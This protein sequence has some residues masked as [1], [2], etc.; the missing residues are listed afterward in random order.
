MRV[1][2]RVV[3]PI[4]YLAVLA[5]IALALAWMAFRPSGQANADDALS[6]TG[7][8]LSSQV[9]VERGSISNVLQLNGRIE[10]D[11]PVQV[12]AS[13]TGTVNHI[14]AEPGQQVLRGAELFQIRTEDAPEPAADTGEPGEEA[15]VPAS[16]DAQRYRYHTVT[17]PEAGTVGEFQISAG[18]EVER[19]GVVTTLAKDS[20]R[21][22]AQIEPGQLYRLPEVPGTATITIIG[23]PEP[24]D[25]DRLR[26][27]QAGAPAGE[28]EEPAENSGGGPGLTCRVPDDVRVFH[29]L[30]V[31]MSVEA[32][33]AD[34][35]LLVPVTAV[36]GL[37]GNGT[38]WVL[39]EDGTSQERQVV[40]GLN[41]GVMAEIKE[42]LE[43][44]E[45]IEEY[46]PGTG[47]SGAEDLGEFDEFGEV[48][49][50]SYEESFE[51]GA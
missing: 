31:T 50:E 47:P 34:D 9:A 19:G 39:A 36:R 27:D 30:P 32:G 26:I 28:G 15:P 51:G 13:Q 8:L 40:V 22:V 33:T 37:T 29:D 42:G 2:R 16:S 18:D 23:G 6:P 38:V 1:F 45:L 43:E 24:F 3:L 7:E 44:G 25:C 49:D 14:F 35:V 20:F 17:A 10:V 4:A 48:Y 12:K 11:S 5:V 46:V 41:D 21:A